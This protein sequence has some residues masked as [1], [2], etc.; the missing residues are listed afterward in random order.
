MKQIFKL[1]KRIYWFTA[2]KIVYPLVFEH[3]K[4]K[5]T[6]DEDRVLFVEYRSENLSNSFKIL[7][8]KLKNEYDFKTE[9]YFLYSNRL[10]GWSYM[11][12]VFGLYKEVVRAK[13]IF[14][15]DASN[16]ISAVNLNPQTVVTQLWHGC[17]AFKKFGFSTSELLFGDS[18]KTKEKYPYYENLDYVTVSSPEVIW[19]YEEAMG[20]EE[21]PTQV[22]ACGISRTDVFYDKDFLNNAK[23]RVTEAMPQCKGKKIIVYAPTFRGTVEDAKAPDQL[24]VTAFQE[25]LGDEYVLLIKHHPFVKN[26]PSIAKEQRSFAKDVTGELT[27]EDLI[28]VADIC[29]SDYSSL[30]FE[31]SLFEKP[32]IFFAYDL[33][34]YCDWRGFYYDYDELTP[35]PV[36]RTNDEMLDYIRNL[37]ERFDKDKIIAFKNKFMSGCD[38]HATERIMEVV[39][40]KDI[41]NKHKKQ[42][43]DGGN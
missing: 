23:K 38:G 40:K 43:G 4:R 39:F 32:M 41:L 12:R 27:I 15:E 37:S 24:D 29:I 7:Y 5:A 3:Y 33:D 30:I 20:L 18:R 13:Y 2:F 19:A 36:C 14:L 34:L 26:R 6:V 31:Y 35:G 9:V 42:H 28:C 17:G 16:V 21:K 1:F 22:I 25:M 10:H 11:K 8:E